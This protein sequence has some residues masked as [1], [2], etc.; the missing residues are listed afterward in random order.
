[1]R[2]CWKKNKDVLRHLILEKVDEQLSGPLFELVLNEPVINEDCLAGVVNGSDEL[3]DILS[4]LLKP[5]VNVKVIFVKNVDAVVFENGDLGDMWTCFKNMFGTDQIVLSWDDSSQISLWDHFK[6]LIAYLE[7]KDLCLSTRKGSLTSDSLSNIKNLELLKYEHCA[8]DN[9]GHKQSLRQYLLNLFEYCQLNEDGNIYEYMLPYGSKKIEAKKILAFVQQEGI[10]KSGQLVS[11][12]KYECGKKFESEVNELLKN[13]Y[14]ASQIEFIL[15]KL[16]CL[17]GKIRSFERDM[18]VS[19]VDFYNLQDRPDDIPEELQFFEGWHMD[20]FLS[21]EQADKG[22]WDWNAFAYASLGLAQVIG[23]AVLISAGFTAS[24]G[25]RLIAEGINDM[26]YATMAGLT[27]TFSWKDYMIQKCI[28]LALTIVTGGLS[29][30][31]SPTKGIV[32]LGSATPFKVF[33][34][35]VAKAAKKFILKASANIIS[36]IVLDEVQERVVEATVSYIAENILSSYRENLESHL[37]SLAQSVGSDDE[38]HRVCQRNLSHLKSSL[39]TNTLLSPQLNMI[40]CQVASSLQSTYKGIADNMGNSCVARLI[41]TGAKVAYYADKAISVV[42]AGVRLTQASIVLFD[43]FKHKF[44]LSENVRQVE[45]VSIE[46]VQRE[47]TEIESCVKDFIYIILRDKLRTVVF[48]TVKHSL[49]GVAKASKA[50]VSK[51]VEK[52]SSQTFLNHPI[53]ATSSS[54]NYAPK[55]ISQYGQT[56]NGTTPDIQKRATFQ[57]Q[58]LELEQ[59]SHLQN[60]GNTTAVNKK[61]KKKKSKNKK[62]KKK[63]KKNNASL[64]LLSEMTTPPSPQHPLEI[65]AMTNLPIYSVTNRREGLSLFPQKKAPTVIPKLLKPSYQKPMVFKPI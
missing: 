8:I 49:K 10:L 26:I 39:G 3:W 20:N 62:K 59:N 31:A 12:Y 30:L 32:K 15:Q 35:T 63:K 64:V 25:Q 19:F 58:I 55:S 33:V 16:L 9:D 52:A 56:D 60:D 13:F 2:K 46:L 27:G 34:K 5:S 54:N 37:K 23:G 47:A 57:N 29:A 48:S 24:L 51:A 1:M 40:R 36:D 42:T 43:L 14:S 44:D 18:Q 50:A 17:H 7:E 22:W 61:K 11:K 38:F 53:G 4:P 21:I 45:D 6:N 41:T 28:N 65:E